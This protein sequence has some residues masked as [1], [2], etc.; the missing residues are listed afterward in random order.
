[1]ASAPGY[2]LEATPAGTPQDLK[3]AISTWALDQFSFQVRP[4][5]PH[6][7]TPGDMLSEMLT[8][9]G[10]GQLRG[11]AVPNEGAHIHPVA[12]GIVQETLGLAD[13]GYATYGARGRTPSGAEAVLKKPPFSRDRR[14]NE[15][16]LR[17]PQQLKITIDA[18]AGETAD[19]QAVQVLIDFFV[20]PLS[21]PN[22]A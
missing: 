6:P 9:D 14:K 11:V 13:Q 18:D 10:V 5:N 19:I 16:R 22:E 21:D 17:G 7:S 15:E 2:T 12:E 8:K 1:M 4:F 20:K 3:R